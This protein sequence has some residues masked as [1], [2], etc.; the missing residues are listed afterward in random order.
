MTST[1]I[2][3]DSRG[4]MVDSGVVYARAGVGVYPHRDVGVH[5][6]TARARA[7]TPAC[8][9]LVRV[10]SRGSPRVS[11]FF[12]AFFARTRRSV[13]D[14]R[15]RR[16]SRVARARGR[17]RF[18]FRRRDSRRG[19]TASR[20]RANRIESRSNRIETRGRAPR[21]RGMASRV[22]ANLLVAGGAALARAASQAYR[23]A[24]ANAQRTGVAREA[25]N[26]ARARAGRSGG[27]SMTADEARQVLGVSASATYAEVFARY[28]RLFESNEKGGSFYL[29]SKVYRARESLERE[30]DEEVVR[31]ENE[32]AAARK[33]GTQR[34][35]E[36]GREGGGGDASS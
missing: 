26:A 34:A 36:D 20:G 4:L 1:S 11:F 25:A 22:L 15:A 21:A 16:R 27:R 35:V 14:A 31:A 7:C 33:D 3:V 28:E 24:L 18:F 19:V 12:F 10:S 23:Q 2:G 6:S 29:Q 30:Y 5:G 13:A 8:T 9:P 32:A 17:R